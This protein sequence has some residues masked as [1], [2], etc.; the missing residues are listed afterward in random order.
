MRADQ[1]LPAAGYTASRKRAQD[2]ILAGAVKIDGVTVKKPSSPVNEAIE[3]TVEIEQVFAYVSRGGTKLQ[4]ALDA[5]GI[6]VNRLKA[7]DVGA[8]TGGLYR[9]PSAPGS[10]R[11]DRRGRRRGAASRIAP[12]G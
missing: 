5:F 8:S 9:L 10:G 1:Y 2:L 7:V 6:S 11:G 4:A 12:A 3:H